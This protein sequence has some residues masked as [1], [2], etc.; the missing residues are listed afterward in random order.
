MKNIKIDDFKINDELDPY[1]IA[2]IGVNHEG[3]IKL[4]KKLIK[5]ANNAGAH[6][7]KFQ[8][9]KANKLASKNSPAYWDLKKE[10][11][12][13][14]FKLFKKFDTFSKKDYRELANYCKKLR[15]NFL[16]TPF[17]LEA[18]TFLSNLVPAFKIASADITNFPLLKK[19]ASFNKPI[20]LS[21]GASTIEEISEAI[22]VI[23]ACGNSKIVLLHCILNYP[24]A[25]DK[26]NLNSIN[27]LKRTF[28]DY[29]IGYSDHVAPNNE[30]MLSLEMALLMG[31]SVIEKHFTHDKTLKGN[32]HYHAMDKRDLK[33][34]TKKITLYR[35]LYGKKY[36]DVS[37]QISART[38]ARRS[39]F[40]NRKIEKGKKITEDC[41]IAKRP[42]NGIAPVHWDKVVGKKML[43]T[44]EDDTRIEWNMLS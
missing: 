19:C 30:G 32:D 15:I 29:R 25:I 31:A 4:A 23:E 44:I 27:I 33:S 26:A 21:V 13:S 10:P 37:E 5:N 28:P 35:K 36:I 1:I 43:I 9:Y 34:F 11:T 16:S 42:G 14:Q 24:T 3:S 18:A 8:T 7:V 6:A 38:N 2:E 17:D 40:S 12:N 41:I 20:I 39:I 22:N